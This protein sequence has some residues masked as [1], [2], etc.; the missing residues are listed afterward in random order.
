MCVLLSSC[1]SLHSCTDCITED[2]SC[3]PC[4]S[5]LEGRLGDNYLDFIPDLE[6]EVDCKRACSNSTEGC[7]YYTHYGT[8][9]TNPGACFLLSS[10]ENPMEPCE[11][12]RT[13]APDCSNRCFF[14]GED[15]VETSYL[16]T[17]TEG[18]TTVQNVA[19]GDG[20]CSLR[21]VAIGGGGLGSNETDYGGG[22]GSGMIT[23]TTLSLSGTNLL[24]V[25][26]GAPGEATIVEFKIGNTTVVAEAGESTLNSTGGSG[27]SGGGGGGDVH[28]GDGGEDGGS[29]AFGA[30]T[31]YGAGGDG[32][33]VKVELIEIEVFK[34]T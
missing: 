33:G 27:Y 19:L 11:H 29:G 15:S 2:G 17:D 20:A 9:S 6:F 26:V 32:S 23:T 14:L 8:N 18:V 3:L 28:N 10:L 34:L 5:A 31:T 25:V 30:G 1:P 13:G 7:M 22:G 4:S 12:C 16:L 21:V 24:E